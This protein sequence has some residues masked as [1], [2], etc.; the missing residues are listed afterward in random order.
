MIGHKGGSLGN[1]W[2]PRFRKKRVAATNLNREAEGAGMYV[3]NGKRRRGIT[4]CGYMN[5]IRSYT[6]QSVMVVG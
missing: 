4:R 3:M 6:T 1:D 2:A 5:P